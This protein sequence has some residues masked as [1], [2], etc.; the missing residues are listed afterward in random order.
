MRTRACHRSGY[1]PEL[2]TYLQDIGGTALLSRQEEN[3]LAGRIALGDPYARD[4]LIRANLRL[5]V[6]LARSYLGRGLPLEDLIAEG[7]LGL[8]RAVEG[9]DGQAGVRFSTYASF[10]IKQS[11]R[12][13]VIKQGK[14]VRLPVHVMTL[15]SK[16]RQASA[17]LGERLGRTPEPEEV[18]KVLRLSNEK[19][20]LV[21]QAL[22]V[23]RFVA[24]TRDLGEDDG[25]DGH[26]DRHAEQRRRGCG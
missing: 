10:W 24:R 18:A 4:H 11:I 25:R 17:V 5:V 7:N 6:N 12:N 20:A 19:L 2:Q 15:L 9:Y 23:N 8:M 26:A 3:E 14:P 21:T 1:A 13:A 16:W 22:E